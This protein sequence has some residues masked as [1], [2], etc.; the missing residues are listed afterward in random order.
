MKILAF[1]KKHLHNITAFSC[2]VVIAVMSVVSALSV[3]A[4]AAPVSW[5]DVGE[6]AIKVRDAYFEYFKKAVQG[7]F[8]GAAVTAAVDVPTSWLKT[9]SDGVMVISPLDDLFYYLKDGVL[10]YED[11]R[12]HSTAGR[13]HGE[14]S[15]I[16]PEVSAK[17]LKEH[18]QDYNTRYMP[19]PNEEQYIISWQNSTSNK[20]G[21]D[22]KLFA[23]N[24]PV[25][26]YTSGTWGGK[27]W[28]EVYVLPFLYNDD[29]S[30][31]Y[32]FG[33]Y[34]SHFY[35]IKED[36]TLTIHQDVYDYKENLIKD[37]YC[38][39]VVWD[40]ATYPYL[41]CALVGQSMTLIGYTSSSGLFLGWNGTSNRTRLTYTNDYM[42]YSLETS[43]LNLSSLISYA[44][45]NFTPATNTADDW[46]Y[47]VSNKPFENMLNQTA[48]DFDK[49]PDNYVITISGDTIYNYPITNPDTGD[50]TTIT[51]YVSNTYNFPS[52]SGDDDSGS[53]SSGTIIVDGKVDV[54]GKVDINVNVSTSGSGAG[55]GAD[56]TGYLDKLPEQSETMNDYFST[57][58][59]FLPPEFLTLMISGIAVAILCRV[60]GR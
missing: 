46:G 26:E 32:F 51:N 1:L 11:N 42:I 16:K 34:Y 15:E 4:S 17:W 56:L 31:G 12:G 48:I 41:G 60:L 18:A 57:F 7:D 37:N 27:R 5:D 44:S 2:A 10:Q 30:R 39:S 3:P 13:R 40:I 9:L 35:S 25:Y 6:D 28:N 52:G 29:D 21:T 20:Y 8:I 49:I 54:G 53:G 43:N 14:A 22:S 58:F 24:V 47:I 50:S 19:M 23:E 55:D 33:E 38:S 36:S 59:S 45:P